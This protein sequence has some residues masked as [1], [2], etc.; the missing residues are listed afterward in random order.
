MNNIGI[1]VSDNS[2][3]ISIKQENEQ[4][5]LLFILDASCN[6]VSCVLQEIMGPK[7]Y[8]FEDLQQ[9]VKV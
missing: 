4:E 2:Q 9:K 8:Y 3:N 7:V 6:K 5:W 1:S